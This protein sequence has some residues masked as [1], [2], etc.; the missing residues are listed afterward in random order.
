VSE[1]LRQRCFHHPDRVAAA[2][3]LG[4]SRTY[5]RECVTEHEGR[6]LCASCLAGAARAGAAPRRFER[7][8]RAAAAALG[9]ATGW[10]FFYMLGRGLLLARTTFHEGS[11]WREAAEGG[12]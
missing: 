2:R 11:L 4:C 5:C 8:R 7:G 6:V 12:R 9:L 1:V 3:C 10:L